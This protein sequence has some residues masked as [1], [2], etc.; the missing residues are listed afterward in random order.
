MP[1]RLRPACLLATL[2]LICAGC[3]LSPPPDERLHSTLWVQTSAEY[4]VST[5][6]VY[7]MAANWLDAGLADPEWDALS[8]GGGTPGKPPAIIV[9]VDDTVLDNSGHTAR[10][11]RARE[12][13]TVDSWRAWVREAS[14]PAVPGA[15]EYLRTAADRGIT[16]FYITNRHHELEGDTRRNLVLVG[17]PLAADIDVVLTRQEEPSWGREKSS[18]R[19]LVAESYRV[20]QIVGD[21][22]ADFVPL[23]AGVDDEQRQRLAAENDSRWGQYWFMVPNP[24]YGSWEQALMP[25]GGSLFNRPMEEKFEHLETK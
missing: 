7:R 4:G 10:M 15:V 14:A 25:G 21:D 11:I 17:C 24:M 18:R 3:A 2:L 8:S 5:R 6:Q 16:V 23:P 20:L 12:G 22:L 1:R 13:F 19:E 9:D